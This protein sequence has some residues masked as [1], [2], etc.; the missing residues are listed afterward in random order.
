MTDTTESTAYCK[1]CN[2]ELP[3]SRSG[4]C[5]ECG[6]E[7][8]LIGLNGPAELCQILYRVDAF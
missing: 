4:P 6:G 5:P 1:N 7:S 8:K 2:I 3:V